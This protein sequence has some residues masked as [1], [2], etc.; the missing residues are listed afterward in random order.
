MKE[1]NAMD[2]QQ[3]AGAGYDDLS[4]YTDLAGGIVNAVGSGLDLGAQIGSA[5]LPG[6]QGVS[7]AILHGIGDGIVEFGHDNIAGGV[8]DILSGVGKGVSAGISDVQLIAG[9]LFG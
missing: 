8:G 3:V 9:K 7:G 6:Y 1:L 4:T 5:L 2:V